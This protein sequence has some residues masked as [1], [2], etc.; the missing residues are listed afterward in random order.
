MHSLI[1]ALLEQVPLEISPI[2]LEKIEEKE[3][4]QNR[5]TKLDSTG[6]IFKSIT[7]FRILIIKLT[8][9]YCEEQILITFNLSIP[10]IHIVTKY[11]L[12]YEYIYHTCK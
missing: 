12:S 3:I 9:L 1:A 4:N 2:P 5:N 6:V 11:C 10:L 8:N 7:A